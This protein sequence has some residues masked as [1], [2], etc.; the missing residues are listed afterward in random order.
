[1][2]AKTSNSLGLSNETGATSSARGVFY[3]EPNTANLGTVTSVSSSSS[4][5]TYTVGT[6]AVSVDAGFSS[7]TFDTLT[8][9]AYNALIALSSGDTITLGSWASW[10]GS[11]TSVTLDFFSGTSSYLTAYFSSTASNY[12]GFNFGSSS[13]D[14]W[15]LSSTSTSVV[16]DNSNLALSQTYFEIGNLTP[17]VSAN[18]TV[19]SGTITVSGD[20]SSSISAGM[21]VTEKSYPTGPQYRQ[22]NLAS[23]EY[24]DAV[25]ASTSSFVA[26]FTSSA[27]TTFNTNTDYVW[28]VVLIEFP[29]DWVEW[30]VEA[31]Y[32]LDTQAISAGSNAGYAKVRWIPNPTSITAGNMVTLN[33]SNTY[34]NGNGNLVTYNAA[35][36]VG[37]PFVNVV[38]TTTVTGLV[39]H[40][41]GYSMPTTRHS[42]MDATKATTAAIF[43]VYDPRYS[44][45]AAH[46]RA[47]VTVRRVR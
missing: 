34:A 15:S 44:G 18:A 40:K 31:D 39:G 22:Y 24:E 13:G 14:T 10:D 28:G 45:Y 16:T 36:L 47:T 3:L 29:S 30:V 2:A 8:T 1:M 5:N 27:T 9:S 26:A 37:S 17:F 23:G 42:S 32:E 11:P 12:D 6:D 7:V 4:N 19:S 21:N 38:E 41:S 35:Q 43:G 46:G 25:F 33:E 20:F